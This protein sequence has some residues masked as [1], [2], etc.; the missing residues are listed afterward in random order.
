MAPVRFEQPSDAQPRLVGGRRWL[1]LCIV[2][3]GLCGPAQAAGTY[4]LDQRFGSIRFS[5][6]SAGM[7]TSEGEFKRF[8]SALT[9]DEAHPERSSVV[10]H[11]DAG[12]VDMA[13]ENGTEM[14]RSADYFDVSKYPDLR[15][16]S[17]AIEAAG[18]DRY[19]IRG[20]LM[21]RGVT[22]PWM[23]E[24]RM[25]ERRMDAAGN[26]EVANFVATGTLQRSEFGMVA[27]QG[28]ISDKVTLRINVHLQLSPVRAN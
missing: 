27:D 10:V 26:F 23:L 22:R 28:F 6:E 16:T 21:I 19:I 24:A 7:F 8:R 18:S 2:A 14:L 5:V 15:F 11:V 4:A 1:L 12:S 20:A 13:W 17:S 9:L 25:L 3:A